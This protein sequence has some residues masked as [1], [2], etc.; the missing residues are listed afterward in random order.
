M[1]QW[2]LKPPATAPSPRTADSSAPSSI[3][4]QQAWDVTQGSASIVVAVLDTG[5]RFDHPDLRNERRQ[6]CCPATT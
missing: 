3:N 1:G 5:V 6:A 4:A 2:Y